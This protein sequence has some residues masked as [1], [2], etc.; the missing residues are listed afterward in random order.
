MSLNGVDIASY[1]KDMD[2]SKIKADFVIIKAT[3]GTS[4]VNPHC[5]KHYTQCKESG[6]LIGLYHYSTGCG[7]EAE[8]DF[9][10][11]NVSNYIKEAILC[12]DWE[13][14]EKGG[15]NPIFGTNSEVDYVKRFMER[16][17][18]R[19]GV[20]P[21]LYMSAS[22]TRRRDWSSVAKI[23]ELW[24]AQYASATKITDFQDSPWRDK[25]GLGA[26]SEPPAIHQYSSSGSI[27]GYKQTSPNKL[28]MD[29]A[30]LTKEEWKALANGTYRK[31]L[32][33]SKEINPEV[34]MD[35]LSNNYGTGAERT[36]RLTK[37]GY[38]PVDVQKKINECY[39]ISQE[40]DKSKKK[41]GNYWNC[42]LK[43][44]S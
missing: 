35:V 31:T 38:N 20:Y 10:I 22:V 37:A 15:A 5:N 7:A 29:I 42:V 34:I 19:T 41:A 16:V 4:Y 25:K 1:Q 27:E 30:Y 36:L 14:N 11:K 28:D 9:F 23:C 17:F 43:F 3:Q 21:L 8:A 12:L 32:N 26:W 33:I 13:H 40:V 24:D 39:K 6:K 18:A 44:L 2:C